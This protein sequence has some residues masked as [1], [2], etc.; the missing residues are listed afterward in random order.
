VV[1]VLGC[2]GEFGW[3]ELEKTGSR[4]LSRCTLGLL[5]HREAKQN[6]YASILHLK[7][8]ELSILQWLVPTGMEQR[9]QMPK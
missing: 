5:H 6:A 8:V 4:R 1:F 7:S 2:G 3:E 9:K